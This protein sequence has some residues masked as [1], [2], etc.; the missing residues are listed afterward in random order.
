MVMVSA[1][2]CRNSSPNQAFQQGYTPSN[3]VTASPETSAVIEDGLK[4][5]LGAEVATVSH[6]QESV[7]RSPPTA[8]EFDQLTPWPLS[9]DEAVQ[10]ALS[11][12]EVMRDHGARVL[13]YPDMVR[14]TLDPELL[15]SDPN[16]GIDACLSAFDTQ[17]QS[18][19]AWNGNGNSV[20]SA[21]SNGQFGVFSQPE[22]IAKLGVGRIL[23]SGTNVS[24]GGMGG[25]DENLA[26]G[27]YAAYGAEVR[28]PLMRGSG[29]E[30]N[31]IAGPMAKS[32][33]YRG[34]RIAQIDLHQ[35]KL[36]VEQAVSE[37]VRD[38]SIVYWE[39]FFA[40]QNLAAK[41]KALDNA[42]QAW[43]LEQQRVEQAVSPPDVE[44]LARQQ[45]YSAEAAVRNAVCGTNPGQT[46]VYSVELKLRTL[47][48][49]PACDDRLI[50]PIGPPLRAPLRFDW[51]ESDS[52][53]LGSRIELRKQQAIIDKRILEI[54]AAK[55]LRLPQLDLIAQYRRLADNPPSD[56]ELFGSALQG[57]QLGVDYSRPVMNRRENAA[58]RHAQLQL[59]REQAIAAEQ[60]RQITAQ[61]RTTFIDLD[62]AF[63]TMNSMEQS[64][65]AS[66]IRLDA[67]AQRHAEG[68][69]RVEDVLEAQIRATRAETEF[70]RSLVDYNLAF[71]K[72]HFAR[73]TLLQA[74]G[75]GFGPPTIDEYQFSLNSASVFAQPENLQNNVLGTR[76]ASPSAT[77]QSATLR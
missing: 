70:Q 44:A 77:Q 42:R 60:R 59:K 72:V 8:D 71:I 54:K 32:G 47:L 51:Q 4:S 6:L 24:V 15:R 20:N 37:L 41:R 35:A 76:I 55:N 2:G 16:L 9:L 48:A 21:F 14:T 33:V 12:S 40:H 64:R 1:H 25:Y 27:P 5:V 63:G 30:F 19:F 73:G 38:V 11:N 31:D 69:V 10:M 65:D 74:M 53:A 39:L 58:V 49:L 46:G 61:L 52:L 62:R 66:R 50:Q 3:L 68:D 26:G 34:V 22:T 17:I 36:E 75:V 57:W 45:Y 56:T 43:E 13:T 18:G 67:Q 28:H 7:Q 29:A 23:H